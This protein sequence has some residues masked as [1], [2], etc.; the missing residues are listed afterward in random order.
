M[1]NRRTFSALLLSNALLLKSSLLF[2]GEN[3]AAF[4]PEPEESGY[5]PT[6]QG[7]L[8]YRINGKRHFSAGKTPLVC[9]HGG[10]GSSHHYL[11]PLLD[12]ANERPVILYDQLDCGLADRPNDKKNWTVERFV[13]E[14]D[15]LRNALNLSSVALYGNSC[16]STWIAPYAAQNPAGL[17]AIIFASPYLAAEPFQKDVAVLRKALPAEIIDTLETH[18]QAGSIHS[19]EYH[20]AVYTWY[21]R[22]VCRLEV[23]P[24]HLMRT[25]DLFNND[26]YE[27]MWGPS[28]PKLT[29]TLDSFDARADLK[30][31]KAPCWFVCGEFD[32]MTPATTRAFAD[33][34]PNATFSAIKNASH[35]PHIEQRAE[36][37]NQASMF[38]A[39]HADT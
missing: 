6:P 14:I 27:Y 24:D 17:E 16:R 5:I 8:W 23:W 31:I 35:T 30:K 9:L 32:E 34:S 7:R 12:L 4:I 29:G 2:A 38:L 21:K 26:L 11:L 13:S 20:D 10:P 22:H 39:K 3:D 18:E 36:F 19:D 15:I 33:L 28:E 1:L 37:I 25:I